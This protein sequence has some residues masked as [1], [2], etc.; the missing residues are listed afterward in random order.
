MKININ[1]KEYDTEDFNEEQ[2][3]ALET[4]MVA[5]DEMR[6]HELGYKALEAYS[7]A[8][9]GGIAESIDNADVADAESEDG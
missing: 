6:R 3:A 2:A 4:L 9:A 7:N 5:Q 8:I 1:D